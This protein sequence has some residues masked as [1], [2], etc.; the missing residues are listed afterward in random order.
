MR[1]ILLTLLVSVPVTAAIDFV[2]DVYPV[3]DRAGCANCHKDTGVASPTRL[4]FPEEKVSTEELQGFGLSLKTFVDAAAPEKSLLSNK[5]TQRVP[6]AGGRRI[7]PGSP[8]EKLLREWAAYLAVTDV[9]KLKAM[10]R[11]DRLSTSGPVLRRLTHAQYNNT[12]RDLLGDS[13]RLADQFPPEDFVNGFRNQYQ[14][15]STSPMLAESYATAAEKLARKAFLSGDAQNLIP[16]KP[17]RFDDSACQ[18]R[19]LREFGRKAFR[20]PLEDAEIARYGKVFSAEAAARK[21]F[22]AGAQVV[23]EVMLQSPNF[24][25]RTE[26]GRDP[27]FR[28]YEIASQLSYFLW[29]SMPDDTLLKAAAAGELGT[30]AGVE[31]QARRMLASPKAREAVDEFIAEW[32]RFDRLSGTVRERRQYPQFTNELVVAMIEETRR[33]VSHLVWDKGNFMEF[34]SGAYTY[35]NGD[36]AKLY[37][38][39]APKEDYGRVELPPQTQRA[40]ILGQ[41]SFLTMTSKPGETSPTSRGLAIREQFLCQEVPQ[42]PPGVNTNLPAITKDRPMTQRERL[43]VHLANEGCASCHRLIDPIGLG[44]EK[45]D[46]IGGF[47]PKLVL[48]IQPA[49]GERGT[50][51]TT[52]E[53][54]LNTNGEIAG[55]KDSA[56]SSPRELGIILANTLQCQQCVVKQLFRWCSGRHEKP[57]DRLIIDRTFDDFAKSGFQFQELMVALAKW[58]IHPPALSGKVQ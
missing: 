36:L 22:A 31:M 55:V 24:L 40:G 48:N 58:S 27:K 26:N 44:L 14:S 6:H 46:A 30:A 15:Q 25:L 18:D 11:T 52:V 57:A 23:V 32:I 1:T 51:A 34:F 20:R 12:V 33:M 5:P 2:K 38:V 39:P 21:Q 3:L 45:F 28:Q 56:F 53:L 8:D 4:H 50:P 37:K 29:N 42:P 47:R 54:E 10:R 13:S 17:R 49:R 35:V 7:Q 41:S 43:S 9:S 19:F 16:C